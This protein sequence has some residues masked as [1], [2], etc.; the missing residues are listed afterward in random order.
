MVCRFK[1]WRRIATRSDRNIK[2]VMGAISL[3]AAAI[4]WL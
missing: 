3:A 2:N 4:C 1:D